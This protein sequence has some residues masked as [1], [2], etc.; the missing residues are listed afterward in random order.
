MTETDLT[1]EGPHMNS[2]LSDARIW[3]LTQVPKR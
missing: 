1:M 2:A 3:M